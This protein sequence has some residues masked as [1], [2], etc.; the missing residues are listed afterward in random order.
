MPFDSADPSSAAIDDEASTWRRE[1]AGAGRCEH[2]ADLARLGCELVVVGHCATHA[3]AELRGEWRA[4]AAERQPGEEVQAADA[5][6]QPQLP[7][8]ENTQSAPCAAPASE[9]D[10]LTGRSDTR[11]ALPHRAHEASYEDADRVRIRIW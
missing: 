9:G 3:F 6:L 1:Y 4:H 8:R 11:G 5:R 7:P 2:N 10:R